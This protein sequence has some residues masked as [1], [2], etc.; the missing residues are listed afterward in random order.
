MS[1]GPDD[2]DDS[3]DRIPDFSDRERC[4]VLL[5]YFSGVLESLEDDMLLLV[6]AKARRWDS[7][8]EWDQ[9]LRD[10][11]DGEIALRAM[12]ACG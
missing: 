1:S 10:I 3:L 5:R 7:G 4:D 6:R 9:E 11:I 2:L 8:S 12:D